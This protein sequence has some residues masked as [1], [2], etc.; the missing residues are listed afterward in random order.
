M[1]ILERVVRECMCNERINRGEC[2]KLGFQDLSS[3]SPEPKINKFKFL[4][5]LFMVILGINQSHNAGVAIIKDNKIVSVINEERL[6]GIKNYWG[7]PFLSLE[8]AL[9]ESDIEPYEIDRV[10]IANLSMLG[11]SEGNDPKERVK[12]IYFKKRMSFSRKIMYIL[13]YLP[14]IIDTLSFSKIALLYGKIGSCSKKSEIKK[15]LK[16]K[17]IIAP[18]SF[19]D[20]H[21]SHACSA[22]LTSPFKESLVYTS[23]FMGDFISGSVYKFNE[24]GFE[25]IKEMSFYS[26]PGMVYTWITFF[27]GFTPGKHEG[28][29]TG[30]AAYGNPQKTYNKFKKYLKLSNDKSL[31]KRK[32]KGF[33]YH[34]A[35][36]MF[37]RDF[38]NNSRE[39]IAAG[40]QKRFEDVISENV[41]YYAKLTDLSNISLAGGVF[42][43]VKLN[44]RILELPSIDNV[45]IH[46]AMDDGG[47]ALGAAL[48]VWC[49]E[50]LIHGEK[51]KPFNISHVYFGPKYSNETIEDEL[52][53]FKL[54][55]EFI[56][57]IEKMIG[58]LLNENKVIARFNDRM[59]YGPRALG[60]RS[61]L[62]HP[63]DKS[64]NKWLNKKLKRSEFMPFAPATLKE[65]TKT[66]YKNIK[67][68][69]IPAKFMTIT[70]NVTEEFAN[71]CSAVTHVDGTA[72]P[73]IVDKKDNPSFYKIIKEYY[74]ISGISTVINTSFNMHEW[75]IVCT[76]KNAITS[77]LQSKLDFLA[78]GNYLVR[79][80]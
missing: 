2:V 47:L 73:Q 75:P 53:K 50:K 28:K 39:D 46:P 14:P 52:K 68:G 55:Y 37:K 36:E 22:F 41:N 63:K 24:D 71:A 7:F 16:K 12:N 54:N 65:Y 35:I 44:Q 34:N 1:G 27:L 62:Y 30:L 40:L 58:E 13:S 64:V 32:I 61:I 67:G 69:E 51:A 3:Q 79:I 78:I 19:I 20:H 9:K 29:I 59:E 8:M 76:P 23:D 57:D 74:K 77:F 31:F 38:K 15:Y 26:S 4:Y 48:A 17:G 18:V 6:N 70:F 21:F 60:N 66:S 33:W 43:N 72:R 11:E 80:K 45:F 56:P 42:A 49:K 10:A 25:K 5:Y